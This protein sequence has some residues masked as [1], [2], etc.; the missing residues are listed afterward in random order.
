MPNSHSNQDG[1][2]GSLSTPG[3]AFGGLCRAGRTRRLF[4][5]SCERKLSR[6]RQS[7]TDWRCP[8]AACAGDPPFDGSWWIYFRPC[9]RHRRETGGECGRVG[10]CFC[11]RRFLNLDFQDNRRSWRVSSVWFAAGRVLRGRGCTGRLHLCGRGWWNTFPILPAFE[12]RGSTS[13]LNPRPDFFP[14]RWVD[15]RGDGHCVEGR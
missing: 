13:R 11:Q 6:L 15:Q 9:T 5:S 2:C 1:C 4:R 3:F 10:R 14:Q 8:A 12:R 7:A